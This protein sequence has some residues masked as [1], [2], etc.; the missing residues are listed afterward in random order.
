MSEPVEYTLSFPDD[1]DD[2]EWDVLQKGWTGVI[3]AVT[4][5]AAYDLVFFTPLRVADEAAF[6]LAQGETFWNEENLVVIAEVDRAHIT[7]AV[8]GLARQG[9]ETLKPRNDW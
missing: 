4:A 6:V 3:R 9:F 8:A 1:F 7:A 2:Y 5:A